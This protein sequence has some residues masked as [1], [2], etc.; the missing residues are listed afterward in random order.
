[1]KIIDVV[2]GSDEWR[3]A[4]LGIPTASEFSNIVTATGKKSAS[5]RKY[6]ARLLAEWYTGCLGEQFSSPFMER[7]QGMEVEAVR[8]YEFSTGAKVD[9][10]GL[11]VTDDGMI[12]ASPDG[13]V[14]DDGLVEIKCLS[15]ENHLFNLIGGDS[16]ADYKCQ[17]QGQMFVTGR[18]WCD[19]LLYNPIGPVVRRF[20]RDEE[21]LSVLGPELA[22]FVAEMY[23][24]RKRLD[25]SRPVVSKEDDTPF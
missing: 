22:V 20:E 21:Y 4:R 16:S 6:M 25:D 17:M 23:S 11:C 9:R 3:A 7:G 13:L 19:L 1:M 2:Q 14:G 8:F 5:Q 12:G 24:W 10:C 18:K 15:A